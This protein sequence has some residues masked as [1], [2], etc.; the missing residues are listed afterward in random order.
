MASSVPE[1]NSSSLI[2]V[3][4]VYVIKII[5]RSSASTL[6]FHV[7][8]FTPR[9]GVTRPLLPSNPCSVTSALVRKSYMTAG[10]AGVAFHTLTVLR[11]YHADV[12]KELDED[13]GL[14]ADAVKELRRLSTWR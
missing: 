1:V 8:S 4:L 14:A 2:A 10:Q 12:L 6:S 3:F 11:A 5:K 7:V 9:R 13:D